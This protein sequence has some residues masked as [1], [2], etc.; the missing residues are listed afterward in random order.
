[1]NV[2]GGHFIDDDIA[3]FDAPFFNLSAENAAVRITA[4]SRC[5]EVGISIDELSRR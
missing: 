5:I 3:L 1:M 2:L 4:Q